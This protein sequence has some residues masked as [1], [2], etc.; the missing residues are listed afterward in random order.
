MSSWWQRGETFR[1]SAPLHD[2][3]ESYGPAMATV[4]EHLNRAGVERRPSWMSEQ[5]I[6]V[7]IDLYSSALSLAKIGKRLGFT[8][9]TAHV[10][11]LE[12]SV[13]LRDTHGQAR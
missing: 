10:R 1:G 4:I 11:S 2:I 9:R 5:E 3:G 12:R 13:I 8:A 7:V 6:A